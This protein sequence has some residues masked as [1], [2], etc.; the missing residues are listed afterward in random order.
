MYSTA[1]HK[2]RTVKILNSLIAIS[3]SQTKACTWGK[4]DHFLWNK[5][6]NRE[7][8]QLNRVSTNLEWFLAFGEKIKN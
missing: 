3:K 6:L 8:G 5:S 7:S 4:A 2:I 1:Q